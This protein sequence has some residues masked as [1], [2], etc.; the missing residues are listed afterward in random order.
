MELARGNKEA[1]TQ[2]FNDAK[3]IELFLDEKS[4]QPTVG[5]RG[6]KALQEAELLQA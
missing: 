5:W 6:L 4:I 3:R 2:S 1:A